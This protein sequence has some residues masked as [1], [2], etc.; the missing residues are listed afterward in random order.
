MKNTGIILLAAGG[1]SRLGRPKQL[2]PYGD[3][4]LV[5]H[6]VDTALAASPKQLVM[7]TG[8]HRELAPEND[9]LHIE[10]NADW[11]E[12]I[13]SSIRSGLNAIL[14]IEPGLGAVIFIVCDQPYI[15]TTLLKELAEAHAVTGKEIVASA[16]ADTVGIPALFGKSFFTALQQLKG[17]EGAKRIIMQNPESVA[18]VGFPRGNIDIDTAGDY[19]ALQGKDIPP[20]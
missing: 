15:S 4:T 10:Y 2:L 5:Q 8:A 16:Y 9:S 17:D 6:V 14:K 20:V 11:Q 13:A 7:V 19:A 3:K 12:G 18:V 1:S